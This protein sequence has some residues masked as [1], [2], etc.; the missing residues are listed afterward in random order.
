MLK[1]VARSR[2]LAAWLAALGLAALPAA[3][4]DRPAGFSLANGDRVVLLGGTFIER[5]ALY[6]YLETALT[7][8]YHRHK[9]Q[10]RNL[11]WS[12][13]TVLGDARAGFGTPADGFDHLKRHVLELEPTVVLLNYGANESFAGQD[14]LQAFTQGLDKLLATL[15]ETGARVVFLS[16]TPHE[17]L[18]RPLPD[19]TEHNRQL[20]LYTAAIAKTAA[21]R[22][23]PFADL[24]D[25]LGEKLEPSSEIPLTDNGLHLTES[26]YWRAAPLIEQALG[27]APRHWLIEIDAR[28]RNIAASGPRVSDASFSSATIDFQALD[29]QLPLPWPPDGTPLD[30][31]MSMPKRVVRVFGLPTGDYVLKIDGQRIGVARAERWAA[32]LAI[33]SG[34][35]FEQAEKLRQ[36]IRAKNELYFHRWR[37]QNVT[38]LFGFRKHE[39]GN[40][41]VEIPRFDPLIEAAEAEIHKLAPPVTRHY[42]ISKIDE[43]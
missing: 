32:G 4:A 39:Q 40:N 2:N 33:G 8:R 20:R 13:D 7:A 10:F 21:D 37:P 1:L 24:F 14:G 34:P 12:G 19:P 38:Y 9:I 15:D 31:L 28:R 6:G 26:G 3:G 43:P 16:P 11:G 18:G 41:A 30:I 17:D 36:A 42:E 35:D 23:A 27:L 29:S 22:G 5:G 25:G